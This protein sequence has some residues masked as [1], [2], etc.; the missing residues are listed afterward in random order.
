MKKVKTYKI[1]QVVRFMLQAGGYGF[2][3]II[4]LSE[5]NKHAYKVRTA[6]GEFWIMAAEIC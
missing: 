1:G 6:T 4:E 2:G 3:E 5:K